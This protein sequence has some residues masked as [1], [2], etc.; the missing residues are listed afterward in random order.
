MRLHR[1]V[2]LGCFAV[3]TV[4]YLLAWVPVAEALA[5]LGVIIELAGWVVLIFGSG[6]MDMPEGDGDE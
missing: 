4:F 2:T 5:V 3:A 6:H 1:K